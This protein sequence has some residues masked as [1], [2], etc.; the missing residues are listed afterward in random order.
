[1]QYN[2]LRVTETN[3]GGNVM[4]TRAKDLEVGMKTYRG[5]TLVWD[6][7]RVTKVSDKSGVELFRVNAKD[8]YGYGVRK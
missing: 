2:T 5:T 3:K 4:Y 6:I 7:L 1:M 8:P